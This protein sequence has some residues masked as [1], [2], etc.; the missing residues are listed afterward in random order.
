MNMYNELK[1]YDPDCHQMHF[2]EYL[3]KEKVLKR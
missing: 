3:Y 1:Q 2:E